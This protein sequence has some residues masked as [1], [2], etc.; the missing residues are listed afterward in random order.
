MKIKKDKVFYRWFA[1]YLLILIPPLIIGV[2]VYHGALKANREQA[3]KLNQSL[4]KIVKNEFDN[5]VSQVNACLNRIALDSNVH[6]LSNARGRFKP[7]DQFYLYTLYNNIMNINLL[8]RYCDDVFVYFKNTNTVVSTNGNMSFDL[9][10]QLY[11]KDCQYSYEELVDYLSQ[12]HFRD[13]LPV[14]IGGNDYLFFT[15]TNLKSDIGEPTATVTVQLSVKTLDELFQAAKWDS[16]IQMAIIDKSNQIMNTTARTELF[17]PITY[18]G[19]TEDEG[20]TYTIEGEEYLSTVMDSTQ[21]KW[22]YVLLTPRKLVERNAR[23]IQRMCLAALAAC[24]ILGLILSY[25]LSK[26]NYNPVKG[27]MDLFK[28]QREVTEVNENEFKWLNR[29]SELFFSEF[30]YTKRLLSDNTKKLKSFNLMKLLEYPYDPQEM[31][32]NFQK[33]R[34][35]TDSPYNVVILFV[36]DF[37]EKAQE[38]SELY[39]KENA[40]HK[41]IITNIFEEMLADH[42]LAEI[43]EFGERVAAIVNLPD[44]DASVEQLKTMIEDAQQ[45]IEEKFKFTPAVLMGAIEPGVEGI[46]ASYSQAQEVGEYI[47]LLGSDFIVYDDVKNVQK[48]YHYSI[49]MEQKIINAIKAGNSKIAQE[50][51]LQVFDENISGGISIDVC[52]C[53]IFDLMGTLLKGADE[54]GYYSFTEEFHYSKELSVRLPVGELKSR[55]QVIVEQICSRILEMRK[56]TEKDHVLSNRIEAYI[57]ENYE[58]PDLNISQLGQQ[59][60]M[61]PAYLSSLYKKQTGMG[62]LDYINSARIEAA[63]QLL[64]NGA[65]V[66]EAAQAVGFR[67]SGALIRVF[68]KKRGVTPGQLK[69]NV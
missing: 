40:L 42:Y 58:D 61:T 33:Y 53:L 26:V 25:Y 63:E 51:I 46:H 19:L 16:S 4:T 62:L 48:R 29:Q 50:A 27:L 32:A 23:Q 52:R 20:R 28:K 21:A 24:I 37:G 34:I 56:N 66:V 10:Y 1:S 60:D 15:M 47:K 6:M 5:Q 55:F 43:T 59:F 30:K 8:E 12:F 39:S 57:Q 2:A 65:S 44:R 41:F 35:K 3:D 18:E 64:L 45:M 22:K 11:D 67:D 13:I 31:E 7:E 54:G 69:K 36:V 68:K 49:D 17:D 14:K 9:Y 38:N